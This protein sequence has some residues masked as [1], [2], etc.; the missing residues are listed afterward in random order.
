M[1]LLVLSSFIIFTT[2]ITY[3][4]SWADGPHML[5][6]KYALKL[7]KDQNTE[8]SENFINFIENLTKVMEPL[9]HGINSF[10]Q[11]ATWADL[12]K[13]DYQLKFLETWHFQENNY[14]VDKNEIL[15]YK[16]KH[17]AE[18]FLSNAMVSLTN[19]TDNQVGNKLNE[20]FEKSFLLRYITHV[21]GDIHQPL[22]ACTRIIESIDNYS[23]KNGGDRGGNKVNVEIIGNHKFGERKNLKNTHKVLD[24][25][26]GEVNGDF[27]NY[28]LSEEDSLA[29]EKDFEHITE[30][31]KERKI[32][33]FL[34][35]ETILKDK[36]GTWAKPLVKPWIDESTQICKDR[37]WVDFQEKDGKVK[38][39]LNSPKTKELISFLEDRI[40]QAGERLAGCLKLIWE[41]YKLKNSQIKVLE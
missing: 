34:D 33:N 25:L 20:Q 17:S 30:N 15:Y 2:I 8:D 35:I 12:S 28:P 40:L 39:D 6:A 19:W 29:L 37:I 1:K 4:K 3:V 7:I 13:D 38:I 26:F 24:Y 22:H 18:D 23:A 41:T 36:K 5:V 31:K 14:L 32:P 27:K 21:I 11:S 16:G 9:S 10:T